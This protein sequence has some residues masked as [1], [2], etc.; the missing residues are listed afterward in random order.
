V[1]VGANLIVSNNEILDDIGM[2]S[3]EKVGWE[4]RVKDNPRLDSGEVDAWA[5]DVAA[6]GGLVMSGNEGSGDGT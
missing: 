4:I 5:E 6:V 3:L 1:L 2:E